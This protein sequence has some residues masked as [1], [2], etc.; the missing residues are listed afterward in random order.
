MKR[1]EAIHHGPAELEEARRLAF[2]ALDF[3]PFLFAFRVLSSRRRFPEEEGSDKAC[4][5][6]LFRTKQQGNF[7]LMNTEN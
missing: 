5:R 1:I 2:M 7:Y 6:H 4:V 3:I